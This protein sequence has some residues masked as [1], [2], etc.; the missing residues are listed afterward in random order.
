MKRIIFTVYDD[1]KPQ[2]HSN[3]D[4]DISAQ[5][6]VAE[7]MD[8]LVKNKKLIKMKFIWIDKLEFPPLK[9]V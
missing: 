8:R 5:V 7:Y 6:Q 2:E 4:L 1:L 9:I 3:V